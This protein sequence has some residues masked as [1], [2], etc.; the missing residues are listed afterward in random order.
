MATVDRTNINTVWG[1]IVFGLIGAGGVLVPNQIIV[2]AITTDEYIST[3]TA[4]GLSVR[5]IG[6]VIGYSLFY[7]RLTH[8]VNS[9]AATVMFP[10]AIK[11]GIVDQTLIENIVLGVVASP[12]SILSKTIAQVQTQ[13]QYSLFAGALNELWGEAFPLI[14]RISIAFGV[15]ACVAC[16]LLGDLRQHT[17]RQHVAARLQG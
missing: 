6:Q 3:A 17:A 16:F 14:Y 13:E 5:L 8:N 1:P 10:V 11:T 4:L 2:T 7:N 9:R 12:W 15:T